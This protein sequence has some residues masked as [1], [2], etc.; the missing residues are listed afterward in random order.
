ML[1]E[2]IFF[3]LSVYEGWFLQTDT[4]TKPQCDS[5]KG[6]RNLWFVEAGVDGNGHDR[7]FVPWQGCVLTEADVPN[8]RRLDQD[9]I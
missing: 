7:K 9:P 5:P 4:G 2:F 1:S 6:L 3:V 8:P